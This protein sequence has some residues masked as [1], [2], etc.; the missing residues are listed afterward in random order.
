MGAAPGDPPL[1]GVGGPPAPRGGPRAGALTGQPLYVTIDVDV[2][3]PAIAP[4]TGAP[5]PG[6]ISVPDLLAALRHLGAARV[7]GFDLVEVSPAL[8]PL[9]AHRDHG[10]RDHSRR[11]P[12]VVGTA[13]TARRRTRAPARPLLAR[14]STT[15]SPSSSTGRRRPTSSPRA[16]GST[17]AERS[18]ASSTWR[19]APATHLPPGPAR[20]SHDRAGPL[21]PRHRIPRRRGGEPGPRRRAVVGDMTD[22]RLPKPVDAAICMQDSQGHL[23]ENAALLA[24]L[25]A[26]RRTSARAGSSSSIAVPTAGGPGARWTWTRRRAGHHG[27]HDLPDAARLRRRPEFCEVMRFDISEKATRTVDPA[28]PDPHRVPA[29]A[30]GARR[31]GRRLGAVR[32]VLE[33]QPK[34]PSRRA[35]P[36]S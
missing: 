20:L 31:A 35:P 5:E 14:P 32:L 13:M 7:I 28:P 36:R 34:R 24:H 18:A 27:P 25:R 17:R 33:L 15:T 12:H 22:F 21:G 11:D 10:R 30:P 6:G 1:P 8:G 4:G 2:L 16:S 29:G 26:V 23:L 19:A 9:G 3:D